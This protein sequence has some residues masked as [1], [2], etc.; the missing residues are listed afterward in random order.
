MIYFNGKFVS[1]EAIKIDPM[2][3]GFLLGDGLFE[4]MGAYQGSKSS[5]SI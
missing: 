1:P 4:T 3:R 2:D 5:T